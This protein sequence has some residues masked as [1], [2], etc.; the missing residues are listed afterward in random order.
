MKPQMKRFIYSV[1]VLSLVLGVFA[2]GAIAQ[3]AQFAA[4]KLVANTSFLNIRT[5]PGAQYSVLITVVGGT[6]LPVLGVANDKVWYQV[7]TVAGIGWVNVGFTLARGDFSVVPLAEAPPV[8][9]LASNLASLG[10]GGGGAVAPSGGIGGLTW[11][12]SVLGG[13]LHSGPGDTTA[14]VRTLLGEDRSVIYP[15]TGSAPAGGTVWYQFS[16]PGV[17]SGWMPA[18]QLFLRP[19]VCSA[20]PSAILLTKQTGMQGGPDGVNAPTYVLEGGQELYAL[21]ARSGLVK[22]QTIG[23]DVGWVPIETTQGRDESK[24]N[25]VCTGVAAPS[26]NVAGTTSGSVTSAPAAIAVPHVVIN[27]AF[28][29]IRS[30]PGAQFSSVATVP[31]GTELPVLGIANDNVWYLVQGAFGQGWINIEFA[32]FRGDRTNLPII[33]NAVGTLARPI[34]NINGVVTLYATPN[35]SLGTVG[36]VS[37]PVQVDIVARTSDSAWVQINT[38]IGFGWVPASQVVVGGD[39]GLAPVVQ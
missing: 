13:D 6:E 39:L 24:L 12:V 10:Q 9:G 29:N 8:S 1:L 15:L 22:I 20:G 37:G 4:P 7:S 21:D 36:A 19:L 17:G 11:G 18:H 28:L 23:G 38:A 33:K 3:Q 27:T 25:S 35:T 31:G 14:K 2:G 5:G 34:A 16:I 30:G 32:L 26:G